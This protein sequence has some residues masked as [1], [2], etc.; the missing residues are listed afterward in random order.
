M[1]ILRNFIYIGAIIHLTM[2]HEISW[3]ILLTHHTTNT[4]ICLNRIPVPGALRISKLPDVLAVLDH[5][6][7]HILAIPDRGPSVF[8][9][10][11]PQLMLWISVSMNFWMPAIKWWVFF[12]SWALP[13]DSGYLLFYLSINGPSSSRASQDLGPSESRAPRCPDS[14]RSRAHSYFGLSRSWAVCIQVP[15]E[16]GRQLI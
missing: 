12:R 14:F 4:F 11:W 1:Q 3:H 2:S 10:F 13:L 8:K 5:G 9:S 7:I 16:L 6:L 15:L